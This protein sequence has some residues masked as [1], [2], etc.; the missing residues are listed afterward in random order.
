MTSHFIILI[1]L[2]KIR[3]PTI[4]IRKKDSDQKMNYGICQ[5]AVIH[6]VKMTNLKRSF[7]VVS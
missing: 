7:D 4:L 2:N 6:M 1:T 5:S 3:I